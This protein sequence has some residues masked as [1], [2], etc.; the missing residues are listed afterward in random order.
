MKATVSRHD[1]WKQQFWFLMMLFALYDLAF[2]PPFGVD[3]LVGI[4]IGPATPQDM[5]AASQILFKMKMNP[6]L[7]SAE[8]FLTAKTEDDDALL[9][10]F[11]QIRQLSQNYAEL[12][13]VYVDPK[14]RRQGVAS[15]LI[16]HLIE[17][18]EATDDSPSLC[19]L[20]LNSTTALYEKFGFQVMPERAVKSLPV[21]LQF[22]F[23]AGKAISAVLGNTLVC[24]TRGR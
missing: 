5:K 24:M 7:L 11:G 12:A 1:A 2:W 6:L 14:F 3:A 19:L 22:E 9:V 4:R 8:A 21:G 16:A 15:K 20:T 10:G 18:H 23:A 17:R 13:S